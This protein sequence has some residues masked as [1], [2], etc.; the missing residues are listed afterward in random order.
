MAR[1]HNP[2]PSVRSIT[3]EVPDALAQ[4][5]ERCLQRD[6]AARYATTAELV[7]ALNRLDAHGREVAV[8]A[9]RRMKGVLLAANAAAILIVAGVVA[10]MVRGR[11]GGAP[12]APHEPV[13]VLIADFENH[14]NDPVFDGSIEQALTIGVEG[15]PFITTYQRSQAR[16]LAAQLITDGKLD[17]KAA[18]LIS[19][20]DGVKFVLA[21]RSMGAGR[22]S[23]RRAVIDPR[24]VR[25]SRRRRRAPQ[26]GRSAPGGR[27]AGRRHSARPWRH[28]AR[29]RAARR[30]G[31][32]HHHVARSGS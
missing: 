21:G 16:R 31:D 10:W 19:V 20:R 13:S 29:K 24:W 4:I 15:A 12:P 5:V 26:Q 25:R 11:A 28:D 6:P 22:L 23:D 3:P 2:L 8:P 18:Q 7:Q 32:L 1:M 14:V 27:R 30:V 17:E 9:P